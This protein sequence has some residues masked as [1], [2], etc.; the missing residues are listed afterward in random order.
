SYAATLRDPPMYQTTSLCRAGAC[1]LLLFLAACGEPPRPAG[2]GAAP[3]SEAGAP[4]ALPEP[5][6]SPS[7]L[8]PPDAA[9]TAGAGTAP[10]PEAGRNWLAFGAGTI[11]AAQSSQSRS[12]DSGARQ[13]IDESNFPWMTGDGQVTDQS[14]TLELPARTTFTRFV[15]DTGSPTYLDGSSAKDVLIEVSDLSATDGF[16]AIA[17]GTLADSGNRGGTDGQVLRTT[18]PVPARWL[19]FTAKNN[20]GSTR[21]ILTKELSGYGEQDARTPIPSVSG[22]Y[23]MQ[24]IGELHLKQDG[25]AVIGCYAS[26]E[27]LVEGTIDGRTM[28]LVDSTRAT[29][30]EDAK[31][32]FIAVNVVDGGKTLLSTW[33]GWSATPTRKAYDRFYTGEK[34][35]DAIGSCKHLPDLDG[36]QDVVRDAIEQDLQDEGRTIL[37]GINFDFDSDVIRAE[38]RPTLDKVAAILADRSEWSFAV[39]GHT[40]NIGG[41]AFNQQLSERRAAA[42][43]AYLQ[44]K[45]TDA[46]RLTSS[47]HGFSRPIAP[48]DSEAE[49]AQNR[50]VELIR[51]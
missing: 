25:N 42:V 9:A 43:V 33:W 21:F 40:D 26:G 37:Y 1:A 35:S 44:Q 34:M 39:E 46:T 16:Q 6:A 30:D 3:S 11:V 51:K 50:R 20:F 4:A 49:R 36:S 22:T 13:L 29:R 19:R 8:P 5:A 10:L 12:S 48:N 23:R 14:V 18:A 27:G 15:V 32:S 38:S 28:T 17:Q 31:S 7:V 47:G 2:D 41:Q 24:S 45:G